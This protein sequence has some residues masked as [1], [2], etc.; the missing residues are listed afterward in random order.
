M[1]EIIVNILFRMFFKKILLTL[2]RL[3]GGLFRS[4]INFLQISYQ[5]KLN[6]N[7]NGR[8]GFVICLKIFIL[9]F[10]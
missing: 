1:T 2:F 4:I 5:K 8:L 7:Y 10:S 9:I 3:S 6:K